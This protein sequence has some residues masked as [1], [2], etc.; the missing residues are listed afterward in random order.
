MDG[1]EAGEIMQR[2]R[3][4]HQMWRNQAEAR[5]NSGARLIIAGCIWV[6]LCCGLE[7][8]QITINRVLLVAK[9]SE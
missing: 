6:D 3:R 5:K 9:G 4:R 1:K 8:K 2:L 7:I